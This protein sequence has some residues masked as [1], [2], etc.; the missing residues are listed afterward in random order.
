MTAMTEKH[1]M[2][3][4]I[5]K[6]SAYDLPNPSGDRDLRLGTLHNHTPDRDQKYTFRWHE[7]I[8]TNVSLCL[9]VEA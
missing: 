7:C 4:S 5:N 6:P 1:T 9:Q 2:N 3:T 8:S